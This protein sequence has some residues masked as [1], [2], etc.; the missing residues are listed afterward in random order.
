MDRKEF[1]SKLGVGAAFALTSTCL[2]GCLKDSRVIDEVDIELDLGDPTYSQLLFPG[3]F[4]ITEGVIVARTFDDEYVAAT[5]TC[6]HEQFNKIT[7][8]PEDNEWFC[9]EH[10]ARFDLNGE[11]LNPLGSKGLSIFTV[12]FDVSNNLL[13]VF[14]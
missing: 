1:I 5:I 11:G 10:S 12:E 13:R 3:G 9:T 14:S 2:G 8:R 7:F 6:S 4:V